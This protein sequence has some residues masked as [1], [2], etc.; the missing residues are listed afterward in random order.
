MHTSRIVQHRMAGAFEI[1]FYLQ[2]LDPEKIFELTHLALNSIVSVD[3]LESI[4]VLKRKCARLGIAANFDYR[5][6]SHE[7]EYENSNSRPYGH[8][9]YEV[10][11]VLDHDTVRHLYLT[12]W[13]EYAVEFSTWEPIDHFSSESDCV[14]NFRG[15]ERRLSRENLVAY[16]KLI[17]LGCLLDELISPANSDP[18]VLLKLYRKSVSNYT[19]EDLVKLKNKLK[20]RSTSFQKCL[21]ENEEKLRINYS[22]KLEKTMTDFRIND[23]FNSIEKLQEVLK[24][25]RKFLKSLKFWEAKIN[26][27]ISRDGEGVPIEIENNCDFDLPT[28]DFTYITRC[29]AGP[30][31]IISESPSRYCS[32]KTKCVPETPSCCP[33][34]NDTELSY[35]RNGRLKNFQKPTIFECNSKC[36]CPPNCPNRVIQKGRKVSFN[37]PF[38]ADNIPFQINVLPSL[39]SAFSKRMMAVNGASR[40]WRRFQQADLLKNMLARWSPYKKRKE[41]HRLAKIL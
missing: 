19:P 1:D 7:N 18:Y 17:L 21:M 9:Q 33:N 6:T 39:S 28:E 34:K 37:F 27:T 40:H 29:K 26:R 25:R 24:N 38:Q 10:E 36:K 11:R 14:Y 3:A 31:V 22:R 5:E 30:G 2:Q 16:K 32:C 4:P 12:K 23:T 20:V 41:D 8:G 15:M 35:D 13:K